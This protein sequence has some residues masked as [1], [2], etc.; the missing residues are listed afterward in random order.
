MRI[1]ISHTTAYHYEEPVRHGVQEL[2]LTPAE[3]A[4]QHVVDWKIECPGIEGAAS[5]FDA[6]GNRVHLVNQEAERDDLVIRV[7]GIVETTSCDGVVG[8]MAHEPVPGLF[9]RPT[10]LTRPDKAIAAIAR[11]HEGRHRDQIAL[12]HALMETIRE[13]MKFDTQATDA[14]TKANEALARGHGVCQDFAHVFISACRL[15]EQPARYVTGYLVMHEGEAE[16]EAHH[17]WVEAE[18]AGLGWVGFD[19]VNGISPDTHYVRLGCGFDAA[20]AAPIRGVRRGGS[21]DRL[22][23]HVAVHSEAQQ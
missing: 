7:S 8:M 17:A 22:A 9:L 20:S 10:E 2:R 15:L 3:I 16:A 12:Y 1:R 23:V 4:S 11:Q 19:P 5:Y 18:V 6:F 13:R 21:G 14:S